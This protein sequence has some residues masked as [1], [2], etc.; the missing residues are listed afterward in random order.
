MTDKLNLQRLDHDPRLP[1]RGSIDFERALYVRLYELFR[2]IAGVTN[3]NGE[4]ISDAISNVTT[5]LT[6]DINQAIAGAMQKSANLG[7]VS[8]A[9]TARNNLGLGS[10]ATRNVGMGY[11]D[12]LENGAYGF[13]RSSKAAYYGAI[14]GTG[15]Y[16]WTSGRRDE[17]DGIPDGLSENG[18]MLLNIPWQNG[19][20]HR[21]QFWSS[22]AR[23]DFYLRRKLSGVLQ[24]PVSL[25]HSGNTTVDG[26]GFVKSSSP[27]LRLYS[28]RIEDEGEFHQKPQLERVSKGVYKITGT[29]GLR[30]DDGWYLET[31][32]DRNGNKYFNTDWEQDIEPEN[33]EGVVDTPV[34]VV[35][36]VRT[37]ER[38]WNPQTGLHENGNPV[39]INEQQGRYVTLRFNEL[40]E[41][42]TPEHVQTKRKE[43]EMDND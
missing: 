32:S 36:T 22:H 9:A 38:V 10:A 33:E 43:Q 3:Q 11:S 8:S 29:L 17:I 37:Y 30:I 26:N 14:L 27:I 7:D 24:N 39:D 40:R 18:A 6:E 31:P 4:A 21:V 25:Y 19:S 15:F 41:S 20:Q 35:L 2:A 1:M 23:N 13:G 28:D 5:Q 16:S 34:E 42:E 12:L